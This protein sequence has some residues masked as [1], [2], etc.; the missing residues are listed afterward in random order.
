VPSQ[1]VS[2]GDVLGQSPV[3]KDTRGGAKNPRAWEESSLAGGGGVY[4]GDSAGG[5]RVSQHAYLTEL[6]RKGRVGEVTRGGG[7]SRQK[8]V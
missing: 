6:K 1:E 7:S 3:A 8:K 4:W 2:H 5:W